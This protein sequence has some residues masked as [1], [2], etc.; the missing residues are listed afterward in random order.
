MNETSTK[1]TIIV[2]V[3]FGGSLAELAEH[4][5]VWI[6]DTTNN[7]RLVEEF[8]ASRGADSRHSVT[9]FKV[10][11]SLSPDMWVVEVL[12]S[13]D[14]HH[15]IRQEWSPNVR[16]EIIGVGATGNIRSAL[17]EFGAFT[18]VETKWWTYGLSNAGGLTR[19]FQADF[20]PMP[21]IENGEP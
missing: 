13:V 19:A 7:R 6:V 1:V 20:W 9:T 11:S 2:E 16:L 15:G 14:E 8:W 4:H 12:A 10:D 5:E 3:N 18:V 21:R 17:E